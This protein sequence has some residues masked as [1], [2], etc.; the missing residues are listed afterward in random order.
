MINTFLLFRLFFFLI[1]VFFQISLIGILSAAMD[2]G[3]Y[4]LWHLD[5]TLLD[6]FNFDKIE[7]G[8]LTYCIQKEG[9]NFCGD[10]N[11]WA[12]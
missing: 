11:L 2:K 7:A 6:E 3:R 10:T 8:F 9:E 1:T 5:T 12:M 4:S